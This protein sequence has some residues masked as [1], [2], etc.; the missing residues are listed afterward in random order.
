MLSNKIEPIYYN[1][2]QI[3]PYSVDTAENIYPV[4]IEE[5]NNQLILKNSKDYYVAIVRATIPINSIP[6]IIFPIV[7][8]LSQID[9]NMSVYTLKFKYQVVSGVFDET[10]TVFINVPFQS[11]Y[12]YQSVKPPYQNNGNQDFSNSY[13]WVYDVEWVLKI[14]NDALKD[15][16]IQFVSNF[17]LGTYSN[18]FFPYITFDNN[19]RC[20]SIVMTGDLYN[21]SSTTNYFNQNL[22]PNLVLQMGRTTNENVFNFTSTLG[23]DGYYTISCFDKYNNISTITNGSVVRTIYTMTASQSNINM[24]CP[25]NKIVFQINYGISTIQ[26]YDSAPITSQGFIGS[27]TQST[28]INKPIIPML[29]DLET[30]RDEWGVNRNF[31]QYTTSSITQSRLISMTGSM[32]QSFQISIYWV[33]IFNNRFPLTIPTGIPLSI[34]LGFYPKTTTLI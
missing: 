1:L 24:W 18:T 7:N 14:F 12:S 16:F 27:Q 25:F 9:A 5:L 20:F 13:Y 17:P 22:F 11:Q 6:L 31:I 19:T 21:G 15:L 8:G 30:N 26:E 3:N 2:S 34:K 32:L 29:T 4:S 33:D 10:K 23:F 28:V